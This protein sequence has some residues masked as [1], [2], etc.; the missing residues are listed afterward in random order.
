MPK[1]KKEHQHI[2]REGNFNHLT[3]IIPSCYFLSN[4][5][6]LSFGGPKG[7]PGPMNFLSLSPFQLNTTRTHSQFSTLFFF[8]S[9]KSSLPNIPLNVYH[10]FPFILFILIFGK[11]KYLI[12]FN[13]LDFVSLLVGINCTICIHTF[14]YCLF[15]HKIHNRNFQTKQRCIFF[16]FLNDVQI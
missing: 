5:E 16:F 2:Q 9:S 14:F 7:K 1:K 10:N 13:R 4:L 8:P 15:L 11:T 3:A 6:R 12:S